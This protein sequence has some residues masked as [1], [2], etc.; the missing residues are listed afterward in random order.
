MLVSEIAIQ[1]KMVSFM[2]IGCIKTGMDESNSGSEPGE[3]SDSQDK[4]D[5]V[6]GTPVEIARELVETLED[7]DRRRGQML[8]GRLIDRLIEQEANELELSNALREAM[9]EFVQETG[10]LSE[11]AV[12]DLEDPD[13]PVMQTPPEWTVGGLRLDQ[14]PARLLRETQAMQGLY[15]ITIE[16]EDT[17][18]H[19]WRMRCDDIEAVLQDSNETRRM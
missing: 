12:E 11:D 16:P 1:F 3:E 13:K 7:G 14:I 6:V 5:A 2:S 17:S 18:G 15:R 9:E 10:E 8:A 19:H 4:S